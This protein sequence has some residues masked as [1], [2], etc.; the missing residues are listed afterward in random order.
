MKALA[1]Y[2]MYE[3]LVREGKFDDTLANLYEIGRT[4]GW[5]TKQD[6]IEEVL[7]ADDQ[8]GDEILEVLFSGT[9]HTRHSFF[10]SASGWAAHHHRPTPRTTTANWCCPGKSGRPRSPFSRTTWG[11]LKRD[12]NRRRKTKTMTR[13]R[14]RSG[15]IRCWSS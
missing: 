2:R 7:L 8:L 11:R 1:L 12:R 3:R 5:Q 15:T 6:M 10:D 4:S 14:R 13:P 9:R